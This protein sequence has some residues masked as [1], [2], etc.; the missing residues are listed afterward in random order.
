MSFL[1]N[2]DD[3]GEVSEWLKEHA[4]K[5]CVRRKVYRGFE[6]RPLRTFPK[7]STNHPPKL[8]RAGV[9]NK[10]RQIWKQLWHSELEF[11]APETK[12]FAGTNQSRRLA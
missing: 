3:Y 1:G 11:L 10:I 8:R 5:A 9:A 7:L 2:Y 6:S 12:E 4:W